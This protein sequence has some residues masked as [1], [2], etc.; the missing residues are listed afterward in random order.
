MSVLTAAEAAT[1][2]PAVEIKTGRTNANATTITPAVTDFTAVSGRRLVYCVRSFYCTVKFYLRQCLSDARFTRN[3]VYTFFIQTRIF[4]DALA[5]TN[6][7]ALS[8]MY[9]SSA[10]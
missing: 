5:A 8:L 4:A 10:R 2:T 6:G 1:R 9:M 3:D 7:D